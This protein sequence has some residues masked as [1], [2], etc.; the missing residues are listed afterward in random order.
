MN[1]VD[2]AAT[3]SAVAVI[4][5]STLSALLTYRIT[6]R[7]ISNENEQRER[8]RRANSSREYDLRLYEHR[9]KVGLAYIEYLHN[10]NTDAVNFLSLASSGRASEVP[11]NPFG[12][13]FS[14]A[15]I[16]GVLM[17]MPPTIRDASLKCEEQLRELAEALKRAS[18]PPTPPEITHFGAL[19]GQYTKSQRT[20]FGSL[21]DL[22]QKPASG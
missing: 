21:A 11:S 18:N 19:L 3:I 4:G 5:A 15:P 10:R 6:K 8:D 1:S 22:F 14:A 16:A 2:S 7:S 17:F 20:I 9:V 13:L 12:G